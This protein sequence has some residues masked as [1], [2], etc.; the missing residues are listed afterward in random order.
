MEG[1]KSTQSAGRVELGVA[2]VETRGNEGI[3][4][5]ATGLRPSVGISDD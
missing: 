3:Y 5:E 1:E 4:W 2:S